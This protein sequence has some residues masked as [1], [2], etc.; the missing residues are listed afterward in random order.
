MTECIDA[1]EQHGFA[2][3]RGVIPI[4]QARALCKSII[5]TA[6]RH[7]TKPAPHGYVGSLLR[8][9]QDIAEHLAN[10]RVLG[11]C[12]ELFGPHSRV[13][14][15][16]GTVHGPGVARGGLHADWPHNT[17][18]NS[19]IRRQ[20]G[21]TLTHL[22]TFWMLTDF[23]V[24]NGG[25]IV[26][27]GSHRWPLTEG[28]LDDAVRRTAAREERL[29]GRAGDVGLLD[30]RVWHAIA[31]NLTRRQKRV[32]VIVRYAPWWLNLSPLRRG[33]LDR[34]VIV[35]DIGGRDPYV[36]PMSPAQF[37]TLPSNVRTLCVSLVDRPD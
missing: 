6:L 22:V 5:G 28:A 3:L 15:V 25:T 21:S 18:D 10:P 7:S 8:V 23:T 31:P 26:I 34:R 2:L 9:N 4:A 13:S 11:V 1:L 16:T 37:E 32:A 27:P 30:A 12:A 14:S 19:C 20:M 17:A 36:V 35:E 29:L 24:A 33:S